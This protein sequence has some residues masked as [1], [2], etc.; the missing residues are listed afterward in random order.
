VSVDIHIADAVMG[1]FSAGSLMQEFTAVRA[2]RPK[3]EPKDVADLHVTVVSA[4]VEETDDGNA[5]N[6]TAG[7]RY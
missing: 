6:H 2:Y 3:Y 7:C 4:G 5:D 1:E